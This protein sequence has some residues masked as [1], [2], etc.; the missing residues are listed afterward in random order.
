MAGYLG[1]H[2]SVMAV[3]IETG[4]TLEPGTQRKLFQPATDEPGFDW[5]VR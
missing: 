1:P 2:G 4:A 5:P 3:D